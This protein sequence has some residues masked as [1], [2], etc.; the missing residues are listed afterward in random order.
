VTAIGLPVD[1]RATRLRVPAW[2]VPAC[3]VA[4][5]A[6]VQLALGS[7]RVFPANWNINLADP[8][9]DA[10]HW[11]REHRRSD[12]WLF[13]WFLNPLSD[14][15]EWALEHVADWVSWLPWFVLPALVF[16]AIARTGR[17]ISAGISAAVSLYPAAV[18]LWE[19]TVDTL[20][21][22]VVAVA[23]S[24]AIG[25]AFGVWA[26]L[27]D[28]VER[29]LR[30]VLD[31]MQVVPT[32]VYLIPYVLLFGIGPVPATI[33]TVVY[34]IPPCVRLTALGIRQVP[35]AT[36]E[37]ARIFGSTRRQTLVKVQLPQ[38]TAAIVTGI[39]QTIN[40]ALGIVPIA[41]LIGGGGLGQEVIETIR[42]RRP[43]RG[44]VAGFAFVAIAIVF[45]RVARSF[46][47]R[48]DRA[49]RADA[50]RWR[51]AIIPGTLGVIA[52]VALA[53]R[54]A[55]WIEIPVTWDSTFA[56]PIDD[57]IRWIRDNW[58]DATRAFND[59]VV[60]EL[61]VRG[62]DFLTNTLAWPVLVGVAAAIGYWAS[63]WRL[64][65]G[66]TAGMAVT[67]LVGMWVFAIDTFVQ[68]L[69]AVVAAV[70]IAVP[71]GIW[72]G[73]RPVVE[74]ALG[75][76]LDALQTIPSLIYAIPF[77]MIFT[78]SPVPGILASVLY[79]IPPG[80]RLTA[81]GIRQVDEETVEAATTFG[82]TPRQVLWGVRVPLALPSIVLAVNQVIMMVLAMVIIAG[83]VGSGALGFQAVTALT[84]SSKAGLG[85]EVGVAIVAMAIML[86]RIMHGAARRLSP[87]AAH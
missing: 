73:R 84:S 60:R 11:V 86:D 13:T 30:P 14:A 66:C 47:E 36:V 29:A 54:A 51:R 42:I 75:P 67:G 12:H 68:T 81:L 9:D 87:P 28:R 80:I 52:A 77:V 6:A 74:R 33:A 16:L 69:I 39:N 83:L 38:A 53:A 72:A 4:G 19:E 71:V 59:F 48:S 58:G 76:V 34:A 24:V 25:I 15:C 49:A 21:L 26:G 57:V 65:L 20:A 37:S 45:D 85:F 23:A 61:V 5:L 56:D 41:A 1:E 31:A 70:A 43:G 10:Q 7:D 35:V 79:A 18:G 82:A 55:G 3:I 63:G 40:M 78:V 22:M 27:D 2:A 50:P 62:R 8:I 32:T 44:F 64:A 17:W 46:V